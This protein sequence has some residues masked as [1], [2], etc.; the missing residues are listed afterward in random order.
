MRD[1]IF[2]E[3]VDEVP[4]DEVFIGE[5]L[6]RETGP[7]WEQG[8]RPRPGLVHQIGHVAAVD[9][10]DAGDDTIEVEGR[11][12]RARWRVCGGR[13]DLPGLRLRRRREPG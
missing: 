10:V 12:E 8:S 13:R 3:A 6:K 2:G 9:A 4:D 1:G 7:F 11:Q 5:I